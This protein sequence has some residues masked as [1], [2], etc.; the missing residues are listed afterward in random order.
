MNRDA[1]NVIA[2][3]N[4]SCTRPEAWPPT[5]DGLVAHLGARAGAL[6][7]R[8]FGPTPFAVNAVSSAYG[9]L[10]AS[11]LG[12]YYLEN[13]A[14]HEA[15]QYAA[16]ERLRAGEIRRDESMGTDREILDRRP[17]YLF[18][19]EHVGILRRLGVRLNENRGWFDIMTLGFPSGQER[20]ADATFGLLSPFLPHVA[21]AV[22]LGRTFNALKVRY[23][24]VL[25]A[26]DRL[27]IGV[28]LALE[29][30]EII[31]ANREA[32]RILSLQDG[33]ALSPGRRLVPQEA[34]TAARLQAAIAEV[35]RTASG[36]GRSAEWAQGVARPSGAVPFLVE[37]V[38]LSDAA[39][40]LDGR[41]RGALIALVDPE[42]PHDLDV[43]RFG[44]LY[45]LTAAETEV[46]ALMIR[47]L[48]APEIAERRET[49]RATARNQVAA[50]Y[51][52]TGVNTRAGL[53]HRVVKTLP[54]LV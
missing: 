54:P 43:A 2:A 28:L 48:Q 7:V 9:K 52:K 11:P 17:D 41:F 16:F 1:S 45:E 8:D 37:V 23:N 4:D 20:I 34:D 31:V 21:K 3:I 38:P 30:G 12:P 19:R 27:A 5:I 35:A 22:E 36:E 25:A 18:M 42:S 33:L 51:L 29:N 13:L 6:L 49:Q 46:C 44:A 32:D 39:R 10:M 24:A 53:V 40:E 50:V 47:G 14:H 26:L 15:A